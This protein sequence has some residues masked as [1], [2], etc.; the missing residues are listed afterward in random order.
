MRR[1]V[2]ETII[3]A[4]ALRVIQQYAKSPAGG[5]VVAVEQRTTLAGRSVLLTPDQVRR[6]RDDL[7]AW[8]ELLP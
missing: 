2:H 6:L 4:E 5:L 1:P 8:L 3:G 7:S